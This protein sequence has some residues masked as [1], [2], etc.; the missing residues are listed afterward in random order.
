MT[1]IAKPAHM[2]KTGVL[3]VVMAAST[4]S[5]G[6]AETMRLKIAHIYSPSHYL[7]EHFIKT[8]A[9]GIEKES[10]G[11][12]RFDIFPSGQIGKDIVALVDSGVADI[13]FI[14]ASV[15]SQKFPLTSV[16]ELPGEVGSAC[17]GTARLW[18][19][20]KPGG[21]LDQDEYGPQNLHVLA[22]ATTPPYFLFTHGRKVER[23]A[24][25]RG[26]KIRTSGSAMDGTI[27]ELGGVPLKIAPSEIYDAAVRGT[28]DGMMLP[29]SSMDHYDL[30]SRLNNVLSDVPLGVGSVLFIMKSARWDA[31]SDEDKKIFSEQA[32]AAQ[33]SFCQWADED[34]K[35][36]MERAHSLEGFSVNRPAEDDR[37]A[38]RAQMEKVASEWAQLMDGNGRKG[39]EVLEAFREAQ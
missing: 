38:F 37:V 13:G 11:E 39:T 18:E 8:L 10:N 12:I 31:L 3:A 33:Q 22:V 9:E 19:L 4:T 23:L 21:A 25:L 2:L 36:R 32:L 24:D 6:Q 27:S 28:V 34:Q 35:E 14:P 15:Q 1:W 30:M 16:A 26:L 29:Y 20:S 17:E 5:A 7:S